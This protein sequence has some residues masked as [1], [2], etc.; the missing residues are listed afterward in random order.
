MPLYIFKL[1][2]EQIGRNKL[3]HRQQQPHLGRLTSQA[4]FNVEIR[5]YGFDEAQSYFDELWND[6]IKITETTK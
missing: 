4:E 2:E 3:S 5:D 6:G 1:E